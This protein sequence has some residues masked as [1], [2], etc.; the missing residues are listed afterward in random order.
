MFVNRVFEALMQRLS[1]RGAKESS[2][3]IGSQQI[4]HRSVHTALGLMYQLWRAPNNYHLLIL[5]PLQNLVSSKTSQTWPHA[6]FCCSDSRK[7]RSWSESVLT[8]PQAHADDFLFFLP[9]LSLSVSCPIF[10]GCWYL[11]SQPVDFAD[12]FCIF[13]L[14]KNLLGSDSVKPVPL[15]NVIIH[16]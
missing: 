15:L 16:D 2:W 8:Y 9:S 13:F 7:F 3:G 1:C 12:C 4:G 14:F 11:G 10:P 5:L 6:A